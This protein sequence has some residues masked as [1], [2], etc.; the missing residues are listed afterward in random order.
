MHFLSTTNL[1]ISENTDSDKEQD[2]TKTCR[3]LKLI[4]YFHGKI[5]IKLK[6]KNLFHTILYWLK[7]NLVN[8]KLIS[9]HSKTKT[10][11]LIAYT[12]YSCNLHN[13]YYRHRHRAHIRSD[14][15]TTVDYTEVYQVSPVP[16]QDT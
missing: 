15:Q 10:P 5:R 14:P 9:N 3:K 16:L 6:I 1:K 12:V 7:H 11:T 2:K 8:S 4:V 13:G